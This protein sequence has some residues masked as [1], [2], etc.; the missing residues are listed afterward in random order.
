MI[1]H[2]YTSQ[3]LYNRVRMVWTDVVGYGYG[4]NNELSALV[5]AY[6]KG[7]RCYH[8]L[9][10]VLYCLTKA[11]QFFQDESYKL[12]EMERAAVKLALFYHDA[13]YDPTETDNEGRSGNLAWQGT[14]A[15]GYARGFSDNVEWMIQDTATHLP[16]TEMSQ[17]V[18]DADLAI[19]AEP[20]GTYKE[21]VEK[22]REEYYMY[23]DDEWIGG[24]IKFLE[25]YL[26]KPKFFYLSCNE[27]LNHN[28]RENMQAEL[29]DLRSLQEGH[30]PQSES[31]T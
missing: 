3:T 1:E 15:L 31:A 7:I 16:R 22:V 6:D 9:E 12:T 27:R 21:Y 26:I 10:H 13:I 20:P 5:T 18:C 30:T 8:T 29:L 14:K 28:A 17:F 19:L 25:K 2:T 11:E 23:T 24:R 4:V